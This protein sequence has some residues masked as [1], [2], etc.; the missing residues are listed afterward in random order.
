M[1]WAGVVVKLIRFIYWL[2]YADG[3]GL[4]VYFATPSRLVCILWRYTILVL[5]RYITLKII[6]DNNNNIISVI[7]CSYFYSTR[8][9]TTVGSS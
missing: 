2:S 7:F 6:I 8:Y 3:G 9:N 1:C 4:V 5:T